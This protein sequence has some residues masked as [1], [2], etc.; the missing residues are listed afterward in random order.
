MSFRRPHPLAIVALFTAFV[1]VVLVGA[2][3]VAGPAPR[4]TLSP[5]LATRTPSPSPS[6]LVTTRSH[7]DFAVTEPLTQSQSPTEKESQS[8][9]WY[10]D[11]GWWGV[12]L[13]S[14]GSALRIFRLD[15][16]LTTWTDTGVVVD[17]RPGAHVDVLPFRDGIY[18]ASAVPG[19]QVVSGVTIRRFDWHSESERYVLGANFPVRI[20]D[21]GAESVSIA[22]DS[23]GVLWVAYADEGMI[24]V[25][26]TDGDDALWLTAF[27]PPVAGTRADADDIATLT[28]FGGNRLGIMWSNQRDGAFYFAV[29]ED[30][31]ADDRWV[32]EVSWSGP[33]VADDHISLHAVPDGHGI[34]VIA[35]VK[36]S[37]NDV[38]PPNLE[39]P[40]TVVLARDVKGSWSR[41]LVS[42]VRD[43]VTR[44]AAVIDAAAGAVYVFEG[45]AVGGVIS[46]KRATLED[47]SFPPGEG[48]PFVSSERLALLTRPTSTKMW[49]TGASR[50][51]VLAWDPVHRSYA[52]AVL[53]EE[54]APPPPPSQRATSSPGAPVA[55]L[56]RLFFDTF[57]PWPVG[58]DV[59]RWQAR[60]VDPP[61]SLELVGDPTGTGR[62]A[63]LGIAGSGDRVRACRADFDPPASGVFRLSARVLATGPVPDDIVIGM[64]RGRGTELLSIRMGGEGRFA[65]VSS[66]G[67]QDTGVFWRSATWYQVEVTVDVARADYAWRIMN[68]RGQLL[69]NM[70]GLPLAGPPEA[71][72]SVCFQIPRDDG[73]RLLFDDV[74]WSAR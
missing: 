51:V 21:G 34:S 67:R 73:S 19:T 59:P 69:V 5:S 16:T 54:A 1:S 47:L 31:A 64:V 46:Y 41:H 66:G 12:L 39:A 45:P 42:R 40:L 6:A 9:L 37:L 49:V 60:D 18:V 15:A 30:G 74:E 72:D 52:H 22:R 56:N 44:P 53:E 25:S 24:M 10:T 35:A 4:A 23:A 13:S 71:A 32:G 48:V 63:Q 65:Y 2:S 36:T 17:G 3:V 29:H 55:P 70:P 8:K 28:A 7:D 50:L 33:Q 58:P 27:T 68:D 43:Q 20:S 26:H 11:A 61:E 57:D 62:V 38:T 14:D